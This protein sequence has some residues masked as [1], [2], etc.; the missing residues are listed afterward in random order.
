MPHLEISKQIMSPTLGNEKGP[1]WVGS[2]DSILKLT[3]RIVRIVNERIL[4]RDKWSRDLYWS[5]SLRCDMF[6]R[7]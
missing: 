7:T 1:D 6:F 2:Y 4:L 5:L 3:L